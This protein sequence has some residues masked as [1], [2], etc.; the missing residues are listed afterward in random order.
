VKNTDAQSS[1]SQTVSA[2]RHY[3]AYGNILGASGSWQGQLG[4]GG[5]FGY[6]EEPTGF[7][8][9]GFRHY[10]SSTGRFLTRDPIKDGRNWYVYCDSDPVNAADPEGL[11]GQY[12]GVAPNRGYIWHGGISW[13]I[14]GSPGWFGNPD[15]T[16]FPG[17]DAD[18]NRMPTLPWIRGWF[19]PDI[20]GGPLPR[21]DG[22]GLPIPQKPSKD[23]VKIEPGKI[24]F[25]PSDKPGVQFGGGFKEKKSELIPFLTI[26][27]VWR[28]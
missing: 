6:Q 13:E 25:I 4:Y 5:A 18:Y 9:L 16:C 3:D 28:Y 21:T 14:P 7:R 23:R 1:A 17:P 27:Y 20:I 22:W 8:M 12:F 24:E 11:R 19:P 15:R 26:V 10:D 2:E